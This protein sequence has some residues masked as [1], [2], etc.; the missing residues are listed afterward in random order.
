M[1]LFTKGTLLILSLLLSSF[2]YAQQTY[3][4]ASSGN[5]SNNGTSESRPWKSMSKVNGFD[6]KA[7]DK[8]LFKRGDRWNQELLPRSSGS[9][10][11]PITIGAYGSGNRPIIAPSS[12][13]YGI[14]VRIKSY[15]RIENIHVIAP[16]GGS[17]IAFR[18][19]SRGCEARYCVI[20]GNRSNNCQAGI[21]FSV[22]LNGNHGTSNNVNNNEIFNFFEGILG[23]GGMH[24][25]G[26]IEKNYIHDMRPGGEDGIVAKRGNYNGLII[27]N[28]EIKGWRDDGIDLYGGNNVIV[29][30][31][32][33]HDCA[34]QLNGSGNGIKAGGSKVKSENCIIRYNTIYNIHA[35]GGGV[36]NGISSNG[37]D[38]MS[39]YGN[40][41]Y[42]VKGEAIAIPVESDNI[43]IY[44]NTAISTSKESLYVG[45]TNVTIKN[46][47]LW[48]GNRPLNINKPVKGSNNLF[49]NGAN[50]SN[51]SGSNDIK[52]SASAVFANVSGRDYRLKSGSPAIDKG[53]RISGYNASLDKKSI[54]GNPD[55]GAYEFGGSSA[56]APTPGN[57]LQVNAG[58]DKSLTLP[59]NSLSL[60]AQVSG[61]GGASVSYQWTKKSGPSATL[62]NTT[63]STLE[64]RNMGEGTYVFAVTARTNG[65][66]AA[67]EVQVTV[68]PKD[69][70]PTP[71]SPPTSGNGLRYR[72]YEGSWSYLPNFASQSVRKQGTVA[73]FTVGVRQREEN[74]GIVFSG[75]IQINSSGN[76]T[77][78]TRSDDGS[79]LYIDG[80][81]VVDNDGIHAPRERSGSISLSQGRHAIEVR[82]FERTEGQVLEVRYAG[83]G[84]SKR[85]IPN[86][87]L[88]PDGGSTSPTPSPTPPPPTQ[89]TVT[90][91][92]GPDKSM[93]LGSEPVVLQG[94]GS[95]PNPFRQYQWQ[96]VSGP[97][98][99]M[100]NQ[101]TA[102][103]KLYDLQ[104]GTYVFRFI[105][106]DNR[107]NQGSDEMTLNVR[108]N[109]ARVAG[110]LTDKVSPEDVQEWA[111][112][113]EL[114]AYPNPAHQHLTVRVAGSSVQPGILRIT[115]LSG[116]EVQRLEQA[117]GQDQF[118]IDTQNIPTGVYLLQWQSD[119]LHTAKVLIE[120]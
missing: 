95:G 98:V 41:I 6:F 111:P 48:G 92:A 19:D 91:N 70:P 63:R 58:D 21:T 26:I 109:N 55:I 116:K 65:S 115:D 10:G 60:Q 7:G 77:F 72:Y 90:A 53:I 62:S 42:A 22:I 38:K 9:S 34:S 80:K 56:P 8:V 100:T 78:Y 23:S 64:V 59:A 45:G 110:K 16:P 24:G 94:R 86:N 74:F 1:K 25:G 82:F 76:Y 44:H 12:G 85:P 5:D 84:V 17:G 87:V 3:Y 99:R 104:A 79:K 93:N 11:R 13:D 49:I 67:D 68:K 114:L 14:N 33:I 103:L 18:G 15:I 30:Y 119:R 66:S 96:K 35:S 105:A 108:G 97:G 2:A 50:Q 46:N 32:K 20:E 43:T 28:N 61:S 69:A 36:Q 88:F 4:I 57:D 54:K 120:H 112:T 31:N 39:I 37:G 52:A 102:N 51:Y 29:E 113:T 27:R 81:Q 47:I 71:P 83:P 73:N 118:Q 89:S 75:S 107:N 106:T 101:N 40:L 117:I